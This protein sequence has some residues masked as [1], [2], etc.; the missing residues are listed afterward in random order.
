MYESLMLLNF[1]FTRRNHPGVTS[2]RI[3]LG[4][5][6]RYNPN[7]KAISYSLLNRRYVVPCNKLL[8]IQ[9]TGHHTRDSSRY[10]TWL[11]DTRSVDTH[12]HVWLVLIG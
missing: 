5:Q 12:Y 6:S 7:M 3:K 8:T 11:D 4:E 10:Q 9:S 1:S 2:M